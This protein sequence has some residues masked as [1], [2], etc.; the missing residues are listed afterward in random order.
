[1]GQGQSQE[2]E[3]LKQKV[4]STSA[5]AD[6]LKAENATLQAE[7]AAQARMASA[8]Q[9]ELERCA[10][11]IDAQEEALNQAIKRRELAEELRRSDALLTKR[12]LHAQLRHLGGEQLPGPEGV[13]HGQLAAQLALTAQ[14]EMQTRQVHTRACR[15]LAVVGDVTT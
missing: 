10:T 8:T 6:A 1:M 13:E 14:D 15:A 2:I 5:R 3:A 7:A 11:R 9:D 4:A 12:L